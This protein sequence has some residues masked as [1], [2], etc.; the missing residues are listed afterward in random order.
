[1]AFDREQITVEIGI[2][3]EQFAIGRQ[4]PVARSQLGSATDHTLSF[5]LSC[6]YRTPS[7]RQH[8]S[9]IEAWLD[10][11]VNVFDEYYKQQRTHY[12]AV[13]YTTDNLLVVGR[14]EAINHI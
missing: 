3:H 12:T 6:R 14:E 9:R 13:R 11:T 10:A 4:Q 2:C 8:T 5:H 1:M 7:N